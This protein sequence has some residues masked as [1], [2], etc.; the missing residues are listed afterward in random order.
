MWTRRVS[1]MSL[2][3]ACGAAVLIASVPS[4]ALAAVNYNSSKSNTGNYTF[5]PTDAAALQ[6]C[7]DAGGKAAKQPDGTT[8]CVLPEKP[9]TTAGQP[10]HN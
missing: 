2:A 4:S 3:G 7:K 8:L 6:K 9:D 10:G 1:I 5:D